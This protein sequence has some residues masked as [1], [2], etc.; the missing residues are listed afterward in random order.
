MVVGEGRGAV[1]RAALADGRLRRTL[2]AYLLFNICELAVYLTLLVWAYGEDG[3]R[4]AGLIAVLQLVPAALL[5]APVAALLLRVDRARALLVGYAAQAL[6]LAALTVVLLL[7][8]SF[9]VVAV[10]AV[11]ASVAVTATRPAHHALMPEISGTTTALTAANAASGA[12]EA[13]ATF[14][15]P[16]SAG[17]LLAAWSPGGVALV[18]TVAS[19]V[20]AGAVVGLG[21][22]RAA[23][24]A[25]RP[26]RPGGTARLVLRDPSARLL[27][28]LVGVEYVLVGMMDILLVVLALDLLSM[29]EAGPGVLS[30]ALGVGGVVGVVLTVVLIGRDRLAGYLV[31][32]AVVAGV[33]LVGAGL[34]GGP[35]PALVLVAA[36]GA[37]KL[38]FDVVNRTFVQRLL[39]DRLLTAAFGAQESLMMA[40]TAVGT[41]LAPL[42]VTLVGG[43]GAFALA[44]AVLPVVALLAWGPLRRLDRSMAIPR[45]E[46][47]LLLGVPLLAVLAPR[48]VERL[49]RQATSVHLGPGDVVVAEGDDGDRF[50]VVAAGGVEV[51]QAG[52]PVRELGP[53]G[54]FGELA[55][56]R[57]TPRTATVT[58]RTAVELVVLRREPFLTAVGLHAPSRAVADAH[59][60]DHYR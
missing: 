15:G 59:A 22:G 46:L 31:L 2:L 49:A 16:L 37:G 12:V 24:P 19:A 10:A 43:P 20:A 54:W 32:G 41:V 38:F 48:V 3:V 18:M 21:G 57:D 39:P 35:A 55:L 42:L 28:G 9:P 47:D 26:A 30:S 8:L 58:A 4:G 1:V 5:A 44:G 13:A 11:L 27:C 6:T 51:T 52:E 45:A 7:D 25:H 34:A 29:S 50:F 17:L 33:P 36:C 56:L 60:R 23:G 53:G 40:G 14:L